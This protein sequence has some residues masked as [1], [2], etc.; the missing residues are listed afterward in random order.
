MVISKCISSLETIRECLAFELLSLL[1]RG[2]I[3][4]SRHEYGVER[5]EIEIQDLALT[6]R[7]QDAILRSYKKIVEE[8][9][10]E[11]GNRKVGKQNVCLMIYL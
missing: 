5:D 8:D 10:D 9:E 3:F 2:H 4:D 7:L 6:R 1:Y 11:E